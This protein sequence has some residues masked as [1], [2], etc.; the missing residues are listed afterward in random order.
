MRTPK[1]KLISQLPTHQTFAVWR[2]HHGGAEGVAH[3]AHAQHVGHLGSVVHDHTSLSLCCEGSA[4]VWLEGSVYHLKRHDVLIVPEGAAHYMVEHTAGRSVGIGLCTGC[5]ARTVWGEALLGIVE[6]SRATGRM[7]LQLTEEQAAR[8]E[9]AMDAL[10]SEREEPMGESA[11]AVDGWMS[12]VTAMLQRATRPADASQARRTTSAWLVGQAMEHI[13]QH[14]HEAISLRD[15]ARA[16]GRSPAHVAQLVKEHTGRTV[17]EWI[18]HHRMT[19]ARQLL[20]TTDDS[21]EQVAER[22]GFA[23]VSHFH[24]TFRAHHDLSPGAWRLAHRARS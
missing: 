14:A 24:R 20:L 2:Q 9:C 1:P 3:H 16:V 23:S 11:L 7:V 4:H 15:V 13:S 12:I 19:L 5:V 17:V 6:E 18:T 22:L 10:A 21:L 8:F